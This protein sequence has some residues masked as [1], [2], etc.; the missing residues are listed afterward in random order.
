M[1]K[2]TPER[3]A[4][5]VQE[6]AALTG[7]SVSFFRKQ[8]QAGNLVAGYAGARRIVDPADWKQWLDTHASEPPTR[9]S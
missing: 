3:L 7:L 1:S 8:I 9:K 5:T 2:P 4:Y 6:L